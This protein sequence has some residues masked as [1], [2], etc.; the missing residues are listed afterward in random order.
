M[1]TARLESV[2]NTVRSGFVSLLRQLPNVLKLRIG[3]FSK[4]L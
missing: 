4:C 2:D 1:Q 3:V